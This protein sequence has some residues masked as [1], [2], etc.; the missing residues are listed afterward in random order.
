ME[1]GREIAGNELFYVLLEATGSSECVSKAVNYVKPGGRIHLQAYYPN[2]IILTNWVRWW[3][4]TVTW[5]QGRSAE[6]QEE[7]LTMISDGR[8]KV[9][10]LITQ[11]MPIEKAPEAYE[12]C[13]RKPSEVLKIILHWK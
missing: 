11:E 7:V 10:D 4:V 9:R 3:L 2:P 8:L 1:R 13:D 6:G 5:T 12:L